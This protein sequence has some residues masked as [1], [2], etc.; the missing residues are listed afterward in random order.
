MKTNKEIIEFLIPELKCYHELTK[1]F[2]HSTGLVPCSKCD[3]IFPMN[4]WHID[5]RLGHDSEWQNKQ[6]PELTLEFM[7]EKI[8]E[9]SLGVSFNH[10]QVNDKDEFCCEIDENESTTSTAPT[11]IEALRGAVEKLIESEK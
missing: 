1:P 8:L 9:S 10:W 11:M 2:N 5:M 7:L 3:K 6:N 4:D